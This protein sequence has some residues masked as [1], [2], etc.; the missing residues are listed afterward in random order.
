MVDANGSDGAAASDEN[1]VLANLPRTRPQRSSPRRAAARDAARGATATASRPRSRP[2][3]DRA[4]ATAEGRRAAPPRSASRPPSG[5]PPAPEQGFESDSEAARGSVQPPGPIELVSSLAE[6]F[7]DLAKTSFSR[8][9][10]L[11]RDLV[12]RL[13]LS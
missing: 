8:S 4:R 5:R 11:V 6:L 12:S 3:A 1:G 13:P 10:R 7:G 2:A 9:E